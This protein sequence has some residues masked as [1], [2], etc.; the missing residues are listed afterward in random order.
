[1]P[2]HDWTKVPDGAFHD[3]HSAWIV[4]LKEALNSGML[5][6]GYY[7]LAEQHAGKMIADV[8][9]LQTPDHTAQP[10]TS[11]NGGRA[12]PS[13]TAV[14]DPPPIVGRKLVAKADA[15]Y[16]AARRTLAIRHVSGHRI[17]ALV[18]I[19]SPA[20]KDRAKSVQDFARKA[21]SALEQG[22]HL[23][24]ADLFPATAYDP[25]GMHGAIWEAYDSEVEDPPPDKPFSVVSYVADE[26]PV[27]YLV[28][29][30]IGDALP[31]IALFLELD[32][33]VK[34]PLEATYDAAFQGVPEY[35]RQ[36]IVTT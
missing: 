14:A 1:M 2:V 24:V 13:P 5:P 11:A 20:N 29:L 3:F 33:H 27:A 18:E 32:Y 8:L 34:L 30:G 19:V 22:C 16:R 10:L 31:A 12:S 21:I 17:V 4:H 15:A 9:T 25:K 23:V 35:W 26:L 36:V 6:K 7:A 28:R